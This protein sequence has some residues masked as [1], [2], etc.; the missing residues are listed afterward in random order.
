MATSL[1]INEKKPTLVSRAAPKNGPRA[2]SSPAASKAAAS[3]KTPELVSAEP[4]QLQAMIEASNVEESIKDKAIGDRIR[5]LR[6]KRSMGLVDLGKRTGMS[7]SFLSQLETGRVV[8]TL[9]NLSRIA[10]VFSKDLAYFFQ[11]TRQNQFKTSRAKDRIRL[12]IGDKAA[13]YLISESM[14]GLIPDRSL[15][16]CIADFLPNQDN[17]PFI[18]HIFSGQE[19]VYVLEGTI[20]LSTEN[21][22]QTLE[23]GDTAWIDGLTKRQYRC[24]DNQPA[25]AVIITCPT[26]V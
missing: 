6:L 1:P 20:L 3:D 15:I 10:I 2:K 13:P 21:E 23:H 18:P 9:R 7:A 22:K 8:P 17:S 19:F 14:S 11:E 25:R 4:V 12:S 24:N 5:R 16:P 26:K